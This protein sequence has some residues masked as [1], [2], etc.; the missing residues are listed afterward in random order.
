M[1]NVSA[2]IMIFM[3]LFYFW[4]QALRYL[5]F[6]PTEDQ[7]RELRQRLPADQH[8]FV[9]YGGEIREREICIG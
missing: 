3:F 5:G 1:I 9:S 2:V 6:S 8:G 4:I 7:Q